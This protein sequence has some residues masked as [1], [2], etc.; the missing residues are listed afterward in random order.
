M[1]SSEKA[2]GI[3]V[4][5]RHEGELRRYWFATATTIAVTTVAFLHLCGE[6]TVERHSRAV[7]FAGVAVVA[8]AVAVAV[9][10]I[11]ARCCQF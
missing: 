9:V 7:A 2:V 1:V 5:V 8:I 4:E 6:T 10:S 3:Q 11:G